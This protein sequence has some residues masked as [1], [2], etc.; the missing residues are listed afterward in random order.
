MCVGSVTSVAAIGEAPLRHY[1]VLPLCDAAPFKV[2]EHY[3]EDSGALFRLHYTEDFLRWALL[4][5]R[6]DA[7]LHV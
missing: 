1:F 6:Y 7:D 2:L 4:P 5:P 3:V